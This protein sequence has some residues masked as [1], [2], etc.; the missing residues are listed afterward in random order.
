MEWIWGL[1]IVCLFV[2]LFVFTMC[3]VLG[4]NPQMFFE[5]LSIS[6]LSVLMSQILFLL[7]YTTLF[8]KKINK[9]FLASFY[10]F[11]FL[12]KKKKKK[13]WHFSPQACFATFYIGNH[14]K[15]QW[16]K[17][18]T[19]YFCSWVYISARCFSLSQLAYSSNIQLGA[20]CVG[21]CFSFLWL[22]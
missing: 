3:S 9:V 1:E 7:E 21:D 13:L 6:I 16:P 5:R 10:T 2:W 17:I 4:S 14:P 15:T 12:L 18:I 8:K 19:I 22:L 20:D 11:L